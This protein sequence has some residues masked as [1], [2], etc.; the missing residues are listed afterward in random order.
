MRQRAL[1]LGLALALALAPGAASPRSEGALVHTAFSAECSRQFDWFAVG[2][3]YSHRLSGQPGPITRLLA[4]NPAELVTY[5]G[6]DIGPTFVHPNLRDHAL[7]RERGYPSY[8]KPGSLMFWTSSKQVRRRYAGRR[9]AGP[10][11]A[12]AS[13]RRLRLTLATA[14]S[15]ARLC[16]PPARPPAS[17]LGRRPSSPSSSSST[18]TCCCAAR[19][20]RSRS[21]RRAARSSPPSTRTWSA[22]PRRLRAAS[23]LPRTCTGRRR[24]AASTSSTRRTRGA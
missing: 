22:Q 15:P 23:S 12:H 5:T 21:A 7:V 16:R 3:F 18:R 8:N 19:S 4:C 14:L 6:M 10:G 20:S 2:L 17:L 1:G 24:S 13:S 9:R 11:A